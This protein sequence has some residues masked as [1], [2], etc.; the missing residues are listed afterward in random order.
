MVTENERKTRPSCAREWEKAGMISKQ[1][2]A[3]FVGACT[4]EGV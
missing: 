1:E 3:Q 4:Y 2:Q